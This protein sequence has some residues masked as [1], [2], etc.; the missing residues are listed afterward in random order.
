MSEG[1]EEYQP[2]K[3]SAPKNFVLRCIKCNWSRISSGLTSDLADLSH[4]KSSCNGCGKYRMYL[5]PKC[6]TKC[7]L[8]RI[9]GNK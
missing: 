4:I 2:E 9:K 5:C 6:G 7:P 3:S 1:K 8:K